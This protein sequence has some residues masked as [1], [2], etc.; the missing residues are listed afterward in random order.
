MK[1]QKIQQEDLDGGGK[2]PKWLTL[3][4]NSY[5]YMS[6][7]NLL[8]HDNL[9]LL[10]RNHLAEFVYSSFIR[11]QALMFAAGKQGNYLCTN[12]A[13]YTYVCINVEFKAKH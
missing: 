2:F 6:N 4:K 13:R 10:F 3:S 8:S 11:A 7:P 9:E 12:Q 1:L 5:G